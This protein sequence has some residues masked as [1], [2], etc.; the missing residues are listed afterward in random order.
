MPV[1]NLKRYAP[2][3]IFL[4]IIVIIS[5]LVAGTVLW[6]YSVFVFRYATGQM[7]SRYRVH[8]ERYKVQLVKFFPFSQ[9]SALKEW[10]EK[11][12]KGKVIYKVEKEGSLSYVRASSSDA[13]SALYYKI[14]LAAKNK[15]PVIS[16]KWN[17][18][19]FQIGRAHV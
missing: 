4:N 2:K 16:W 9:E 5:V 1:F 8:L 3:G 11:I 12:F 6:H 10:E 13:A 14:R 15:H 17:V 19:K 18:E 7:P